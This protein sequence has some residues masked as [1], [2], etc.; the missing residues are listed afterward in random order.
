MTGAAAAFL[1]AEL[2]GGI[3]HLAAVLGLGGTLA[4][5]AHIL[6]D[7]QIDDVVVGLDAEDVLVEDDFLSGFSSVDLVNRQFH[8][9]ASTIK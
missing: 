6:E 5:V 4:L 9:Y 8:N 2:L 1:A 7:V 3:S